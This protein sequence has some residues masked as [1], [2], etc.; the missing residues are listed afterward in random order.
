MSS[1]VEW[2]VSTAY[3]ITFTWTESLY[4]YRSLTCC[5]ESGIHLARLPSSLPPFLPK[6]SLQRKNRIS[7]V[8]VASL[9][10]KKKIFPCW[11]I[12]ASGSVLLK[13]DERDVSHIYSTMV[14]CP[15]PFLFCLSYVLHSILS[16]SLDDVRKLQRTHDLLLFQ[17]ARQRPALCISDYGN[18]CI[19]LIIVKHIGIFWIWKD[20]YKSKFCLLHL[21]RE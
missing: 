9:K 5:D 14:T 18:D 11:L 1:Y 17:L 7:I 3:Y 8:P 4:A 10:K 2:A 12:F 21:R 19:Y 13:Y 6:K 15:P 16:F 20:P